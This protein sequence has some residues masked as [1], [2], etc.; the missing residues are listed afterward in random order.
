MCL[1]L[2]VPR[3]YERPRSRA[4]S[5]LLGLNVGLIALVRVPDVLV[6][7]VFVLW[8]IGRLK[9][10]TERARLFVSHAATLSLAAGIALLV[11][12]PQLLVWRYGAGRWLLN[13]YA[14]LGGHFDF[15]SPAILSVLFSL[16]KG[17]FFWSPILLLCLPGFWK[18]A[19]SPARDLFAGG[20][21]YLLLNVYVVSC[22]WCWWYG[23]SFGHRAFVESFAV[24]AFPLAAW[25]AG[26]RSN[27]GRFAVAVFAVLAVAGTLFLMKLFLS[28]EIGGNGL[29]AQALYDIVWAR[30]EW[31]LNWLAP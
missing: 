8:G 12:F 14:S 25:Y 7:L 21:A 18:L 23:M 17:L 30:K 28:C 26:V 19:R 6:L 1:L 24:A 27:A 5:A 31:L 13:G 16:K 9:D 29:D 4:V 11:F 10:V 22:W 2:L 20:T 15:S 3:W